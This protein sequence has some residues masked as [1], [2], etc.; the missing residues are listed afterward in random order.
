MD[1]KHPTRHV[2]HHHY[3]VFD[4]HRQ[5]KAAVDI[6]EKRGQEV[7]NGLSRQSPYTFQRTRDEA[8]P[9]AGRDTSERR[10][11]RG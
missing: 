11:R 4:K 9:N 10:A 5:A 2:F 7:S 8:R 3:L 1:F 6:T